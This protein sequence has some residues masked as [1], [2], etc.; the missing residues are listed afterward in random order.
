MRL[1][2]S[3]MIACGLTF[4]LSGSFA[5]GLM[6]SG[7]TPGA[8][9][10]ARIVCAAVVLLVAAA[11]V[12][13]AGLRNSPRHW[14]TIGGYGLT[15]IVGA[16]LSFFMAIQYLSVGVALMI[17]FLAPVVVIAWDWLVRHR[18]V[19]TVTLAGTALALVG[20]AAVIDVFGGL[21]LS[22]VGLAWAAL[23][24]AGATAFFL[25]AE[26][27][28]DTVSPIVLL[29]TGMTFGGMLVGALVAVGALSAT[30]AT[31]PVV[32]AGVALPWYVA[33]GLL[34]VVSTVVAYLLGLA[35]GDRIGSTLM[36]LV[37][38]SEVLFAAVF[39]WL[40]VGQTITALQ[41]IGGVAIVAGV[42]LARIGGAG[43]PATEAGAAQESVPAS[44]DCIPSPQQPTEDRTSRVTELRA[45]QSAS[46]G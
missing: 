11:L 4:G 2:V 17:Q 20:A 22:P 39:A 33:L 32:L 15:A 44:P 27:S 24:L 21:R 5:T 23:S 3:L 41:A 10:L 29:A 35:G 13:R 25:F 36:S 34:V 40:L 14:R 37:L 43:A 38:L 7:W 12:D 28:A 30:F 9:V 16:Q 18:R 45:A 26:R 31:A 6:R 8:A 19:G 46:A 42:A 1:G